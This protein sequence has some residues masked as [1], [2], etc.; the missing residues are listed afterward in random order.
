MLLTI[1]EFKSGD[2][3]GNKYS[4]AIARFGEREF[5][6]NSDVD[7]SSYVGREVT[8]RCT[9]VPRADR[10]GKLNIVAAE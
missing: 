1:L 8:V 5:K 7:L 2:F 4:F 10:T 9:V 3:E 6:I